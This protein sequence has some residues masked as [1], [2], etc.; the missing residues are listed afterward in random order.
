MIHG[1]SVCRPAHTCTRAYMSTLISSMGI[2]GT[3]PPVLSV[4]FQLAEHISKNLAFVVVFSPPSLLG[5]NGF[6][7]LISG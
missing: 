1:V 7:M 6:D 3:N 5:I 2:P 4:H